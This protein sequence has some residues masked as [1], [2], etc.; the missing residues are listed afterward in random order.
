M[1]SLFA[2]VDCNNFYASCERL[3]RPELN[4]QPIVVLSNNDG[5]VIARSNEAKALGIK[6]GVPLFEIRELAEREGIHVFSSNYELYGD[7]SQRVVRVLSEYSPNV[8]VYSIDESFLDL[9][10]F[11]HVDLEQHARAIWER[12]PRAIGIPV[13]VGVAPT[14]TLAKLA[15]RLA[16]KS[17]KA[18]GVLVLTDP[19]HIEAALKATEIGD[20][21]GVGRRYAKKLAQ[22]GVYTAYD[23]TRQTDSFVKKHLT[24]VGL[25]TV[26][27]LRGEPCI[28]LE[29][30]PPAKQNICTSRGFGQPL[31]E[32]ADIE[33]ALATHVVRCASKLR[34]QKSCANAFTVFLETSRFLNPGQGYFNSRTVRLDSPSSSELVLVPAAMEALRAIFRPGFRYKKTGIIVTGL[35]PATQVQ[36]NLFTAS[37]RQR[38]SSLMQT[39]DFL[40]QRFGHSALR[41]GVQGTGKKWHMQRFNLSPCY[42]TRLEDLIQAT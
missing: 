39:L 20:V 34:K 10:N 24:I 32:V 12:M 40:R 31:T 23:L 37:T 19:S 17:K 18:N 26:K 6:M 15:N 25:R 41:Y 42:T 29:M 33:E 3:F 2:L 14:K 11:L 16:K 9:G 8:E 4:G 22:Y 27:E 28:E 1:T 36:E 38:D 13:A 30:V 35:C 5:C 21:W 7:L